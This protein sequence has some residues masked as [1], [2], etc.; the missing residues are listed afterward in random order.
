MANSY[1][2]QQEV[3]VDTQGMQPLYVWS[4]MQ[5]YEY[6]EKIINYSFR[7]RNITKISIEEIKIFKKNLNEAKF[8]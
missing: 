8:K 5:Q 4:R 1:E 2:W 3:S 6:I 7:S